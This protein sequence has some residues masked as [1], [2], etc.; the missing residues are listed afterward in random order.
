MYKVCSPTLYV[1]FLE[2]LFPRLKPCVWEKFYYA[3]LLHFKCVPIPAHRAVLWKLV[4]NS[5][6]WVHSSRLTLLQIM[7]MSLFTILVE[8]VEGKFIS[9]HFPIQ[10]YHNS[11]FD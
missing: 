11:L 3:Y 7:V 10:N 6:V 9:F 2:R 8:L 1:T 5:I 4:D